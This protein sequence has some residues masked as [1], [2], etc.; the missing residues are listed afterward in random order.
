VIS[1]TGARRRFANR[2]ARS[3]VVNTWHGPDQ[4]LC[5]R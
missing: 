4:R 5:Y 2:M 1:Q 3:T